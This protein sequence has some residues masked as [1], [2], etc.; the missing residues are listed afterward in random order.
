LPI[1][2]SGNIDNGPNRSVSGDR[3]NNNGF[4]LLE[5]MIVIAIFGLI[6]TIGYPTLSKWIPNY[7]LKAAARILHANLQKARIHAV[8]ENTNVEFNFT[9]DNTCSGPTSYLF[10]EPGAG[11]DVVSSI[12]LKE[13]VCIISSSFTNGADGYNSRGLPLTVATGNVRLSH[14]NL[15]SREY[16]INQ[17]SAGSLR[18][19]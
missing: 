6:A 10:K 7:E 9:A 13:G 4:T 19:Q 11:G 15:R 5:V 16:V 8:K 17:T 18:I 12:T 2:I 3:Y 1:I 14:K